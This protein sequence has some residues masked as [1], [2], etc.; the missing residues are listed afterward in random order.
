MAG[1]VEA[2]QS[3]QKKIIVEYYSEVPVFK[4]AAMAAG[5]DEDTLIRWRKED[6]DFA[7]ELYQARAKWVRANVPKA[8][9]EFIL[10]RLERTVFGPPKQQVDVGIDA[11]E[12]LLKEYG[13]IKADKN[14]DTKDDGAVQSPS[15]S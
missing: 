12:V 15:K 10:E 6:G 3:K 13:I 1:E 14:D 2:R 4:Y 8:K 11:A 7:D 5:I 9:V